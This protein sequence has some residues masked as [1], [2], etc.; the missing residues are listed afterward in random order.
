MMRAIPHPESEA[1]ADAVRPTRAA[2]IALLWMAAA[3]VFATLDRN[4]FVVLLEPMKLDLKATDTEMGFLAG[5]A[6]VAF[7]FLFGIPISRL[8]DVGVRRTILAASVIA[9]SIVTGFCS[10]AAS[11]LQMGFARAG[12]GVAETAGVPA[13]LSMIADYFPRASRHRAVAVFQSLGLLAPVLGVPVIALLSGR[14]GW[15]TAIFVPGVI[16]LLLGLAIWIFLQEPLR[17][18]FDSEPAN[19]TK[20]PFREMLE[21]VFANKSLVCVLASHTFAAAAIGVIVTWIGP[22][23]IRVHGFS[24]AA[25]G[26]LV[27]G[28]N[29]FVVMGSLASGWICSSLVARKGDDRWVVG[30]SAAACLLAFPLSIAWLNATATGF[31]LVLYILAQVIAYSRI[32]PT[33][34]LSSD[35]S[36]G[37]ARGL[38]ASLMIGGANLVGSGLAPMLTGMISD[39]LSHTRGAAEGLRLAL[40]YTIPLYQVMAGVFALLALAFMRRAPAAAAGRQ[41]MKGGKLHKAEEI[42]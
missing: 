27:V 25:F 26:T 23:V 32:A 24:M 11:V 1:A 35:L 33:L 29:V 30:F 37:R 38:T 8:V 21:M 2:W 7:N 20:A 17:G 6:F 22:L 3:N 16:G 28:V 10:L 12:L 40:L 42:G 15:R 4:G 5:M 31:F 14:Y 36:P 41:Y 19:A 13:C 39:R 34:T 18:R 9:W